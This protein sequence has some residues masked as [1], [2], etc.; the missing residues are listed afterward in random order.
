MISGGIKMIKRKHH[1]KMTK[2]DWENYANDL[3]EE[4]IK[5]TEMVESQREEVRV[6]LCKT[7]EAEKELQDARK[8]IQLYERSMERIID[9][10]YCGVYT[11]D[12]SLTEFLNWTPAT[13]R[14]TGT[15]PNIKN[16]SPFFN[17]LNL[18]LNIAAEKFYR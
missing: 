5:K 1:S 7:K 8:E 2:Q 17:L 16:D 10:V 6:A 4:L 3:K 14:S 12:R 9:A 13:V 11:I 18:V 15:D